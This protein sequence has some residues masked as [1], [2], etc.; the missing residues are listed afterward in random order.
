MDGTKLHAC[1]LCGKTFV[2]KYNLMRHKQTLHDEDTPSMDHDASEIESEVSDVNN[3]LEESESEVSGS[4]TE[5]SDIESNDGE[6]ED[7]E[8]YQEWLQRA[9]EATEEMRAEKYKKY[10]NEG[11]EED[12]AMEKAYAKTLWSLKRIFF[13]QYLSFLWSYIHLRDDETHQEI[14]DDLEEKLDKGVDL[15]KSIRRIIGKHKAK[16]DGLVQ[17]E[18]DSDDNGDMEMSDSDQ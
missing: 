14:M 9:K 12:Q 11:M 13:D 8:A 6:L 15:N 2:R 7:N 18:D 17:Y 10:V 4:E 1:S 16:F 3:D 5:S